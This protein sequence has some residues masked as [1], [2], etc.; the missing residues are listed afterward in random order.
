M[1]RFK[2]KVRADLSIPIEVL[3]VKRNAIGRR[4][5]V[6]R[7][8]GEKQTLHPGG[9]MMVHGYLDYNTDRDS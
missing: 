4:V 9:T 6:L 3:E 2:G 5:V 1:A 7:V 8:F